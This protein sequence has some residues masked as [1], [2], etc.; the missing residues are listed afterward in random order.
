MQ[1]AQKSMWLPYEERVPLR[2]EMEEVTA[3]EGEK[4]QWKKK[5]NAGVKFEPTYNIVWS[6][7]LLWKPPGQIRDHSSNSAFKRL[8]YQQVVRSAIMYW[9]A[10]HGIKIHSA[11]CTLTNE[12]KWTSIEYDHSY[13]GTSNKGPSEVAIPIVTKPPRR[14]QSLYNGHYKVSFGGSTVFPHCHHHHQHY[15]VVSIAIL[16]YCLACSPTGGGCFGSV[17]PCCEGACYNLKCI[18]KDF[19]I[20]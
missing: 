2:Q 12:G 16:S 15:L 6:F 8:S 18:G 13:S 1:I 9:V 14:G 11:I 10:I 7:Q 19:V 20:D 5:K 3:K 17:F 4:R